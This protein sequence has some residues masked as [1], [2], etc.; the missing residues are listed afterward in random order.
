MFIQSLEIIEAPGASGKHGW[1]LKMFKQSGLTV[2][3]WEGS[4]P[5]G[6]C[7]LLSDFYWASLASVWSNTVPPTS[8]K[9]KYCSSPLT[10]SAMVA[11]W[12]TGTLAMVTTASG[13][14]VPPD[15]L[16]QHPPLLLQGDEFLNVT[17]SNLQLV[18]QTSHTLV[19]SGD[20]MLL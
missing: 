1:L 7:L 4:N 2:S 20:M 13:E 3:Q 18:S 14:R 5:M 12:W 10:I 16:L 9:D 11:G 15:C 8:L 17:V 19:S 6:I